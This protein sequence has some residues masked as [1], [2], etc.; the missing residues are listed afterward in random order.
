MISA[1]TTNLVEVDI[2]AFQLQVRGS[3]VPERKVSPV[4]IGDVPRC[5]MIYSHARSIEAVLARD[6]LPV[7]LVSYRV[8][9]ICVLVEGYTPEGSTDLVTLIEVR[10]LISSVNGRGTY[11]L[12]GLEMDL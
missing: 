7:F 9:I 1:E 12:S 3:I 8:G 2:H 5:Q 6:G 11:A 10:F 4:S